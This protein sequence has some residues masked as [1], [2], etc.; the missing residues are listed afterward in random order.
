MPKYKRGILGSRER[1]IHYLAA[2]GALEQTF[3]A[4]R[5]FVPTSWEGEPGN[6]QN[7]QDMYVGKLQNLKGVRDRC[8]KYDMMDP[9]N[10]P[11]MVDGTTTDPVVIW[12]DETTKRDLLVHWY[13][14]NLWEVI[15]FQRDTN[16]FAA[17]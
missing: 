9:L 16:L 3:G 2:T 11:L 14:I 10:I 4:A 17:E 5:H 1:D 8:V 12:G 7:I 6:Y 15:A 13:Q